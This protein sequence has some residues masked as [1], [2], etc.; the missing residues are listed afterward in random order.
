MNYF[1]WILMGLLMVMLIFAYYKRT[2]MLKSLMNQK[3]SEKVQILTDR[4]F[5]ATINK[6]ITLVDFW[7]AWCTPCKFQAPI[8]SELADEIG[9]KATIGKLNVDENKK[10]AAQ[11]GIRSIP[12]II[13]FKEGKP[14]KKLVGVKTK[15]A[16]LKA[17]DEA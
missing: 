16:L 9:D 5:Q 12:T 6:G 8:I 17:I 10:T 13:V 15:S 4:N 14:V 2:K 1:F 11:F 7:A 3:E